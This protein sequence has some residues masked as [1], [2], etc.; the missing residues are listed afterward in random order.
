LVGSSKVQAA[1]RRVLEVVRKGVHA[2]CLVLMVCS[3]NSM[4]L[5][6]GLLAACVCMDPTLITSVA[7]LS[8]VAVHRCHLATCRCCISTACCSSCCHRC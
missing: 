7:P 4:L 5:H 2:V 1:G 6:P 3:Q 8:T